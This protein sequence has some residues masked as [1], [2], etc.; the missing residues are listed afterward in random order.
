M[1]FEAVAEVIAG[2]GGAAA[3]TPEMGRVLYDFVL[4]SGVTDIVE[5]GF[6][7][8]NST[9]Y[10]AAALDERGSG[11]I[12]TIDRLEARER[13]PNIDDLLARTG[14][15]GLV[16]PVFAQSSYNWV[17][18]HLIEGAR[19]GRSTSP[20]FDFAF[21]DG[22]HTW[23]TDGLAF[24]LVEKLLKPGSWMLFD[25]IHWTFGSSPSLMDSEFV[26]ALPDEERNTPQV[27]RVFS[28][29]TMQHPSFSTFHVSGN[30]GWAYKSSAP[31]FA[32][33]SETLPQE[34]MQSR[35]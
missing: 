34:L 9:C 11:S 16:T 4:K 20:R 29:L 27:M 3:T 18:M 10:M 13:D 7:H 31:G 1:R 33:T 32:V 15:S 12:L 5:L 24:F 21:I 28:L 26:R 23:E 30:W 19:Q 6:A 14:L 2:V 8:G 22:A 35:A 17:L 25:D